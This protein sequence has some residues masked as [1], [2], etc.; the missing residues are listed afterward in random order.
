[1]KS[2]L[3]EASST[4]LPDLSDTGLSV[5]DEL[6]DYASGALGCNQTQAERRLI[7]AAKQEF[8]IGDLGKL[9]NDQLAAMYSLI[10]EDK[11]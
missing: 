4:A 3:H 6:I 11:I 7:D 1:M 9:N 5:V 10:Q 2:T 8:N